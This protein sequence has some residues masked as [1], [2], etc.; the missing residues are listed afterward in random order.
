MAQKQPQFTFVEGDDQ[1]GLYSDVF[2]V[3][4]EAQTGMVAITFY[5]TSSGFDSTAFGIP[6]QIQSKEVRFLSKI[7]LSPRGFAVLYQSFGDNAEAV[8]KAVEELQRLSDTTNN[9]D[10]TL[11]K[12]KK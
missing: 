3:E 4:M 9:A 7:H 5:Q 1:I 8:R 11:A 6:Q 10:K 12:K 2:T